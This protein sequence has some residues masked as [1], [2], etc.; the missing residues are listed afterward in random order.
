[1]EKVPFFR[2]SLWIFTL[3]LVGFI[4]PY[5]LFYLRAMPSDLPGSFLRLVPILGSGMAVAALSL[6]IRLVS[7]TPGSARSSLPMLFRLLLVTVWLLLHLI[8]L[9]HDPLYTFLRLFV[10]DLDL[11]VLAMSISLSLAA[12]FV[13]P[14]ETGRDRLL[15]IRRLLGYALGER[16]PV[17][18][19]EEGV[20]REA[21]AEDR[22]PGP[23]VFLIDSTSAVVLR[24]DTAFTRAV[25]PGVVFTQPGERRAEALDLRRQVRHI[26]RGLPSEQDQNS[27]AGVTSEAITQDGISVSA[28]ISIAFILDPGHEGTP[29]EGRL[30]DKPPYE[31]NRRSVERAVYA[32]AFGELGD[33]PWTQIPGLLIADMWREELKQWSLND[34]LRRV[35]DQPP[36]LDQIRQA[37]HARLIPPSRKDFQSGEADQ[38]KPSRE[39]EILA[40]RG[41]RILDIAIADLRLPKP[42][43]NERLLHWRETWSGEVQT[44]LQEATV[45]IKTARE[46][47]ER[48]IESILTGALGKTML[49]ELRANKRPNLR[50][51]LLSLV[52][53]ALDWASSETSPGF[54]PHLRSKLSALHD[55]L[56]DLPGD[57]QDK[58][59]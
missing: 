52:S 32:H 18:F 26:S 57:C 53:D 13:L 8:F 41:I 34:L 9:I 38:E 28:E 31:F 23:G 20:A 14:V 3:G 56:Q 35:P 7:Q 46:S 10:F 22:R 51:T 55:T 40:A 5:S 39:L 47:G 29:R 16:G 1:M 50:D 21:Y 49:E 33:V 37:L 25:G 54:D 17:T 6:S 15:A 19:V 36:P 59:S 12:Q 30:T 44:A 58:R 48:E 2:R 4:L 24:T 45:R 43:Q 11:L 27:E 42:I